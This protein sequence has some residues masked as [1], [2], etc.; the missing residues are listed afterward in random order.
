MYGLSN[1]YS[2]CFNRTASIREDEAGE[3]QLIGRFI[4]NSALSTFCQAGFYAA[5]ETEH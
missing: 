4:T 1:C 2:G 3:D 5:L